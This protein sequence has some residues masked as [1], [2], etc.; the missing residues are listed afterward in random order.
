MYVEKEQ[1]EKGILT[2]GEIAVSPRTTPAEFLALY[3]NNKDLFTSVN[4]WKNTSFFGLRQPVSVGDISMRVYC[5]FDADRL[6]RIE[7]HPLRA[8]NSAGYFEAE[9]LRKDYAQS[10]RF[11]EQLL[12]C[13]AKAYPWGKIETY[14]YPD[15]HD[16]YHGGDVYITYNK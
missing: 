14:L 16:S 10:C 11:L 3:Q 9:E 12:G 5:H 13:T 4:L 8:P 6:E 1:L 7:L 15:Y 2:V